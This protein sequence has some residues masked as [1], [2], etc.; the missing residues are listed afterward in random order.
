MSFITW[1]HAFATHRMAC[2]DALHAFVDCL[3]G[4]RDTFERVSFLGC[5]TFFNRGYVGFLSSAGIWFSDTVCHP[6]T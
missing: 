5:Y 3:V 6:H 1:L 4:I 2:L